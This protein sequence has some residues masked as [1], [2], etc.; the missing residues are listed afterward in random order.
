MKTARLSASSRC[1]GV[2]IRRGAVAGVL[3]MA[4]GAGLMVP[5]CKSANQGQRGQSGAV[6]PVPGTNAD[7]GH[8]LTAEDALSRGD[9][10]RALE[11]FTRAIS[12]NPTLADAH[13]GV[14]DIYRMEGDYNRAEVSYRRAA[15]LAPQSFDA[16]YYHGLMLHLLDRVT[17]AINA[18]LRALSVSPQ[19]FQA[20]LNISAA[21]Y[22][23]GESMQSLVFGERA[24][25]LQPQSGPARVNLAA[26]YADMGRHADAVTEYQQAFE[27]I[28]P[29]PKLVLGYAESLKSLERFGEMRST[30]EQLVRTAP[31]A[32]SYERL[33]YSLFK[34]EQYDEALAAFNKSLAMDGEHFPAL[35]GLG[36]CELNRWYWSDRRDMPAR[37][38]GLQALRRSLAINPNQAAIEELLSR[39][40]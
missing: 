6:S 31:S 3:A 28:E 30:L 9:R 8:L 7:Q 35:N 34:L 17:D 32:S 24:V 29:T 5:G 15:E 27:L 19:D 18:Y 23:L 2:E 10:Q 16:Q 22:Q 39:Y 21:Y 36:V 13:M 12:V 25:K 38:R 11:E 4:L 26:V 14:G 37:D 33:G 40:R 1:V 20:N